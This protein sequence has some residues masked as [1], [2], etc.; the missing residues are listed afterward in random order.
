MAVLRGL[1][2]ICA[3][4][5][6]N[7]SSGFVMRHSSILPAL[8]VAGLAVILS[9]ELITEALIKLSRRAGWSVPLLCACNKIRK[10]VAV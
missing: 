1:N 3:L 8:L 7:L 6:E 10:L 5:Q 4:S 2:L 9:R